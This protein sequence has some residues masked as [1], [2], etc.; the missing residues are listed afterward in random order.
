MFGEAVTFSKQTQEV[1]RLQIEGGS[2]STTLPR[3]KTVNFRKTPARLSTQSRQWQQSL[4]IS[5]WFSSVY[6]LCGV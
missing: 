3:Q 1:P 4:C 5:H 6:K 2:S